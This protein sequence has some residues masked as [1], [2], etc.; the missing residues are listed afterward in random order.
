M[1]RY[2]P[3]ESCSQ[4]DSLP[5]TS[6]TAVSATPSFSIEQLN[7]MSLRDVV[8]VT[9]AKAG[10]LGIELHARY[11]TCSSRVI[12]EVVNVKD[13]SAMHALGVRVGDW[14]QEVHNTQFDL[15]NA[16]DLDGVRV[17]LRF[18]AFARVLPR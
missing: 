10:A 12:V 3:H 11:D 13:G 15:L 4:F 1:Y 17:C 7:A 6:L 5:L 9:V 2:I 14:V 16:A 18:V 8:G